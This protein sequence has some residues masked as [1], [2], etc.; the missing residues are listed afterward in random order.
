[1]ILKKGRKSLLSSFYSFKGERL[2]LEKKEEVT[3][4]KEAI[5]GN[6]FLVK[7]ILK[8]TKKRNS[9]NVFTTST[10]QQEASRKLNFKTKKNDVSSS[11]T[12]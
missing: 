10:M 1:M 7:N 4:V 11:T 12:L 3:R 8:T 5:V 2:K 9:P 6:E